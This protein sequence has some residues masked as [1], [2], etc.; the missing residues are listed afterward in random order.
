MRSAVASRH[1]VGRASKRGAWWT[2]LSAVTRLELKCGRLRPKAGA[3]GVA[4]GERAEAAP[5]L[6]SG[7]G[8]FFST[9]AMPI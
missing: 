7:A 2:Q 6:A 5:K 3:S 4:E 1:L 9:V 8:C